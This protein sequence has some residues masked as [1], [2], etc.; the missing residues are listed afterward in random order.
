M[1]RWPAP[2][3]HPTQLVCLLNERYNSQITAFCVTASD[4]FD[5]VILTRTANVSRSVAHPSFPAPP[6]SRSSRHIEQS[7]TSKVIQISDVIVYPIFTNPHRRAVTHP[8]PP[9]LFPL[10][11]YFS[12]IMSHVTPP[13]DRFIDTRLSDN[14]RR[15]TDERRRR[16]AVATPLNSLLASRQ[17]NR[18]QSYYSKVGVIAFTIFIDRRGASSAD[19]ERQ[20]MKARA[21]LQGQESICL[22]Y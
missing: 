22:R 16:R 1:A 3:P 14:R 13:F 6:P 7:D 9:L 15:Q 20:N 12:Q 21:A 10:S 19:R 4:S 5:V 18:I 11:V 17:N 2:R 8:T